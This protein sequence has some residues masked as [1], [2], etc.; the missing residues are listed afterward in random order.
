MKLTEE[1]LAKLPENI[2]SFDRSKIW[3]EISKYNLLERLKDTD[4]SEIRKVGDYL[5]LYVGDTWA[6]SIGRYGNKY[7]I[8]NV[9]FEN[10]KFMYILYG[11]A[12]GMYAA[13]VQTAGSWAAL[14]NLFIWIGKW[15]RKRKK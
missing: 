3:Q 6:L 8:R 4:F 10:E 2:R 15:F 12:T 1:D 11:A 13:G 14:I 5:D 7:Y 9:G